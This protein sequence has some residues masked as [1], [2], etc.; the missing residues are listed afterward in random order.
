[1]AQGILK[2]FEVSEDEVG[3]LGPTELVLL[4]RRLVEADL[5]QWG[6]PLSAVHGTLK[7][8]RLADLIGQ[9]LAF[10]LDVLECTD[11]LALGELR[12]L[13]VRPLHSPVQLP[14][15]PCFSPLPQALGA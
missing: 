4:I 11:N 3:R 7:I 14:A 2:P 10:G 13:A 15:R 5:Q 9:R 8:K 1:M 12:R 6:V